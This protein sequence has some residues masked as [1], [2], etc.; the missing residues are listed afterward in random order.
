M[1][2][3]REDKK[4]GVAIAD[5]THGQTLSALSRL[6]VLH[7]HRGPFLLEGATKHHVKSGVAQDI[8]EYYVT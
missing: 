7:C 5:T 2:H 4:T 1:I 6:Y 8:L 3:L